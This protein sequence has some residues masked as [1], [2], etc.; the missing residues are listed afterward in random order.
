M[1]K[2]QLDEW[3]KS[4]GFYVVHYIGYCLDEEKRYIKRG[5]KMCEVYPLVENGICEDVIWEW[6]KTQPI[7]NNYYLTNKRC[8]CMY[9]PMASKMNMAYLLKYYPDNFDYMLEKMRETEKIREAKLGR[10]FSV[11]SGNPKYNADYLDNIIRTK[12]LQKLNEAEEKETEIK[13]TIE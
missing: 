8:G 5:E 9:C 2:K 7:F 13:M 4:L 6:A 10:P 1:Q 3:M 12:W 11:T